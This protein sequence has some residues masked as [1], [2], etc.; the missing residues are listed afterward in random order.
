MKITINTN[1]G[2]KVIFYIKENK[3]NWDNTIDNDAFSLT[4]HQSICYSQ[5]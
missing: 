2:Q 4:H 5:I 3:T 1:N